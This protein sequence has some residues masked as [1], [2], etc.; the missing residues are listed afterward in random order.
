[1][2][3]KELCPMF[4]E[5]LYLS[6]R[7]SRLKLEEA[8]FAQF[9]I[10]SLGPHPSLREKEKIWESFINDDHTPIEF[11]WNW[12]ANQEHPTLRYAIEPIG[13]GAGRSEDF[14]NT[15]RAQLLVK[16][17]AARYNT[18]NSEWFE[19][20]VR[21][22]LPRKQHAHHQD[23]HPSQMFLAFE[24]R[25]P[26]PALK[27]YFMPLQRATEGNET[28][29]ALIERSLRRL[30][31]SSDG[32]MRGFGK[33]KAY[34]AILPE[35]H[36]PQVEI[37]AMDCTDP[38]NARIKVYIRSVETS[39]DNVKQM[40]TLGGSIPGPLVKAAQSLR[41]LWRS[42]L[43]LDSSTRDHDPLAC[44]NHRTA[45]IIYHFDFRLGSD[46]PKCKVYIPVKHY[47]KDDLQVSVGFDRYLRSR[48]KGVYGYS[49]LE[50][51]S[52]LWYVD[53]IN[54]QYNV[55][56]KTNHSS[57]RR[58][59]D[60]LGFHTYISASF[61]GEDLSVTS[62]IQPETYHPARMRT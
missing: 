14:Y 16:Q 25:S 36:K 37:L 5:M 21:E 8:F 31:D 28:T 10:P 3:E 4:A 42:V 17:V 15:R 53:S 34:L 46:V 49:Y 45:G 41:F 50:A 62:Y 54:Y 1:M 7:P 9:I 13:E 39:F 51:V 38:K 43:S 2:W 22:L 11:S 12:N 23:D 60:G 35:P 32:L 27:A 52:R 18:V 48:N 55:L 30:P 56:T 44:N 61:E 24:L 20:F 29:L 6:K 19:H 33:L 57:H 26:I 58:L 40:M 59:S 47:G